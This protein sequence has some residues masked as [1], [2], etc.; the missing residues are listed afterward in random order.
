VLSRGGGG[1]S[2]GSLRGSAAIETIEKGLCR[3]L[4]GLI[5]ISGLQRNGSK[6][7]LAMG[8]L[9]VLTKPNG[10]LEWFLDIC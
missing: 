4:R 10:L 6:A 9:Q 5:Q 2:R 8:L 3:I 1:G 7:V